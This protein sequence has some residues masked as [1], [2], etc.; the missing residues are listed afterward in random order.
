[1][2]SLKA[3]GPLNQLFLESVKMIFEYDNL[4]HC[5]NY[6]ISDEQLKKIRVAGQVWR[7][8]LKEGDMIDAVQDECIRCTGWSQAL[9]T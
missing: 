7:K 6:Q 3:E 9:I 8:D 1:M 5:Y 2:A 4:L